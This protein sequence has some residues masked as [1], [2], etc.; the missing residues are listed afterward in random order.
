[1]ISVI[2][3]SIYALANII[4]YL[5][6]IGVYYKHQWNIKNIINDTIKKEEC[7]HGVK[8]SEAMQAFEIGTSL[9]FIFTEIILIVILLKIMK[10][11]L[12]YYYRTNRI[13]LIILACTNIYF[14]L[15]GYYDSIFS[16]MEKGMCLLFTLTITTYGRKTERI[17]LF[18]WLF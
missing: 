2:I 11:N 15:M 6:V 18:T 1:M 14:L 17:Q 8:V 3:W 7:K 12:N 9:F 16:T 4:I 13:N 10:N 5:Y